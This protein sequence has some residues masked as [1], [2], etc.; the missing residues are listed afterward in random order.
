MYGSHVHQE[1]EVGRFHMCDPLYAYQSAESMQ[2][3]AYLLSSHSHLRQLPNHLGDH[4]LYTKQ[5]G[6]IVQRE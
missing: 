4:H 2:I 6:G 1:S 3:Q 5:R